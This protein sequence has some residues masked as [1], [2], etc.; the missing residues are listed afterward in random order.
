METV[1]DHNITDEEMVM[2]GMIDKETFLR[3]ANQED[4][5]YTLALLFY[6]RGDKR[7]AKKYADRL[8]PNLMNDFWRT[9]THP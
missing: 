4:A 2:L 7:K 3:L 6:Y 1:F 5:N 9:V 8:S